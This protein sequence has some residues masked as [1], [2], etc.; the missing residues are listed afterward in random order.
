VALFGVLF[1]LLLN[2]VSSS[3]WFV[4]MVLAPVSSGGW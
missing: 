3:E 2:S 4:F 1:S